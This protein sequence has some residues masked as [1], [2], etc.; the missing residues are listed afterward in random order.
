MLSVV[1]P[2]LLSATPERAKLILR[3]L[4]ANPIEPE[5]LMTAEL[6]SHHGATDP[7]PGDSFRSYPSRTQRTTVTGVRSSPLAQI[8]E[9]VEARL[10]RFGLAVS[11]PYLD[12]D[13]IEFVAS[14]PVNARP[15]DGRSKS[16]VRRAFAESLPES[17]LTKPR[18]TMADDYLLSQFTTLGSAFTD[19]Y[20][21]V[22]DIAQQFVDA[23]RYVA[24]LRG[25]ESSEATLV[26]FKVLWPVWTLF[27]WLDSLRSLSDDAARDAG[28]DS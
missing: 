15:S 21:S 17:V 10:S 23:E 2:S 6:R 18:K 13:L 24:A 5:G 3:R 9:Y 26:S 14:I 11:H 20:P 27:L 1:I 25:F 12:R 7:D 8:N 16:L 28:T 19:R 4:G 22:P